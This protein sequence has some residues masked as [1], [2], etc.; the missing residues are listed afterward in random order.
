M[1]YF[2]ST[3]VEKIEPILKQLDIH[4]IGGPAAKEYALITI[5]G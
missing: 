5:S 3:Y 4:H 1:K 2:K